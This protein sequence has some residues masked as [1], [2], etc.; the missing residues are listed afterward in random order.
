M[1]ET[2]EIKYKINNIIIPSTSMKDGEGYRDL[3]VINK[4]TL[5]WWTLLISSFPFGFNF[6]LCYLEGLFDF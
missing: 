4:R 2:F 3:I 5:V 6:I 1:K